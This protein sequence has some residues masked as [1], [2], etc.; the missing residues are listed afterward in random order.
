[1]HGVTSD[2][3]VL[4]NAFLHPSGMV[5]KTVSLGVIY[6][7][8]LREMRIIN[9]LSQPEL[10]AQIGVHRGFISQA[11]SGARNLSIDTLEKFFSALL[12]EESLAMSLRQRLA[13]NVLSARSALNI[14]QEALSEKS[15]TSVNYVYRVENGLVNTALSKIQLLAK[16]LEVD[17]LWLLEG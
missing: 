7:M 1:M 13:N 9:N 8:R 11:E 3:L 5:K 4:S 15:G 14:S 10:G 17:G 6:G 12:P 16:A 2:G